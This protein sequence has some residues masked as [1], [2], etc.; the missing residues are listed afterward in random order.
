MNG[1]NRGII[2][3]IIPRKE[4]PTTIQENE[5]NVKTEQLQNLKDN[6]ST[7]YN[8]FGDKTS[9]YIFWSKASYDAARAGEYKGALRDLIAGFISLSDI[10]LKYNAIIPTKLSITMDG[11]GGLVIGH[12]FKIPDNLLPK[13]YKG[14]GLGSK[15]GY[16]ITGIGHSISNNDWVT[17]IDA[18]FILLDDP[19]K[20][21]DGKEISLSDFIELL[22]NPLP[23]KNLTKE[24][25]ENKP[26]NEINYAI[27]SISTLSFNQDNIKT[28]VNFFLNKGYTDFQ[29]AALVGGFILESNM[30]SNAINPNGGAYGIAQWL[31]SRQKQ[32]KQKPNFNTLLVQL[33]YVIEEFNNDERESGIKLKSSP[34][35]ESA[36]AAAA[37]Y[38]RFEGINIR[39][40]VNYDEVLKASGTKNRIGYAKDILYRIRKGDFK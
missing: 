18:Q 23:Q 19:R 28:A 25:L 39:D 10:S 30:N 35:F 3:R 33:N 13:G 15:I 40:G 8:F 21:I 6:L 7:I 32:L 20:G 11:I 17:N 27:N 16:L 26:S 38:E 4:D 2:D 9:D 24:I 34:T 14:G 36:V 29:T 5:E 1:F 22:R 12:I 31:G 37:S